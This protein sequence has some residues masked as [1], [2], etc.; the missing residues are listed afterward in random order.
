MPDGRSLRLRVELDDWAQPGDDDFHGSFAPVD[1]RTNAYG[2]SRRPDGFDGNSE[3]LWV[4]RSD[5]VW[6]QP[7]KNGPKRGTPE[8]DVFRRNVRDLMEFG[9]QVMTVELVDGAD[10][11]GRGTVLAAESLCGIEPYADAGYRREIVAELAAELGIGPDGPIV[12]GRDY[13]HARG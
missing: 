13:S 1:H 3:K 10:C 11:Y 12:S 6:W 8:F 2:Y 9:Y 4:G 7:P 5:E